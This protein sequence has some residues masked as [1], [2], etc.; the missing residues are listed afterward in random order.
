MASNHHDGKAAS[1]PMCCPKQLWRASRCQSNISKTLCEASW[2]GFTHLG[3]KARKSSMIT[4]P[5]RISLGAT[6]LLE[7][8]PFTTALM[9]V[10]SHRWHASMHACITIS[11]TY[12]ENCITIVYLC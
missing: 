7:V 11:H 1:D 12:V 10:S 4:V 9:E 5:A 6:R 3:P 2:F 8:S